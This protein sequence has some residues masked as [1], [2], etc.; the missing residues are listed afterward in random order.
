MSAS[1]VSLQRRQERTGWLFLLPTIVIVFCVSVY[2]LL[3]TFYTSL[4]DVRMASG[5][6]PAFVGLGNYTDLL[7]R[8]SFW[9]AARHT[10][11]FTFCS[12]TLEMLLGLGIAL[13]VH[14]GFRGRGIVRAAMLVPWALPTVVSAKMWNYMLVDTYGVINDLLYTRLHLLPH[15][16]AWMAEPGLAMGSIIAVDVWKTTPFVVLLLLAGLQLIPAQ[17]YEASAVDGASR[18]QQFRRITLPLLKPAIL[19][20]LIFRTLDALRVFDVIWVLT[21][22]QI[23]TESLATYAYRQMIDFRKLGYGS[24]VSVTIFALIAVFVVI[25][26]GLANVMGNTAE[27]DD[28]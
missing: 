8:G 15:K 11:I 10:V 20:V 5:R 16:I 3:R 22:G 17:M 12:V 24:A 1:Q 2:P 25:Y 28:K 18:W 23:G 7:S 27:S 14:S 21:R 6:E 9:E 13:I 4:T 19:V 26:L